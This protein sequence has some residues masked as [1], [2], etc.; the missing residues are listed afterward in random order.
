MLIVNSVEISQML[1]NP[2]AADTINA[3]SLRQVIVGICSIEQ[4]LQTGANLG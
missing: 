4:I 2:W 1:L 3:D